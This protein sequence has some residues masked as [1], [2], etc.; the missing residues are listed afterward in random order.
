[1]SDQ[2]GEL[3]DP[4]AEGVLRLDDFESIARDRMHPAA[5]AYY[6]GGAADEHTMAENTAAFTRFQLRPRVLRDVSR[7]DTTT[8]LLGQQVSVPFGLA[9]NA[10][11]GLAHPDGECATARAAAAAEIV[12][13]LSTF[14]NKPLAEVAAAAPEGPR[15]FQLY[16]HQDRAI[17]Q[18]MIRKAVTSDYRAIVVTV[19]LPVPGYRERELRWPY[20]GT[21]ESAFGN[22]TADTKGKAIIELLGGL[23]N[24]AL[25]WDDLAWIR[26]TAGV[27][28]VVKGVMTS[29]DAALAVEHGADAV[30]VSNHGGRQLDRVPATIEVLEEIVTAIDGR[31]EIYLDGGV[32]RGTD[33]VTALALGAR[34]VFLGRPYLYALA[35]AGEDG[36]RR[37][38]GL[39]ADEVVNAMTLL[40]IT[41]VGQLDPSYVQRAT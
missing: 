30:W 39:L 5:Y 31:A 38:I 21:E 25:T 14:S 10:A 27:P 40:G 29:E 35:V 26:E 2:L 12:M 6:A 23:I 36:V 1:M 9:P 16:V 24:A 22:I 17:A 37:A 20:E 3:P 41:G 33:V 7:V 15:W 8:T 4:S 13:C 19:D 28:L 11:Q 32:R 18:D 34:A